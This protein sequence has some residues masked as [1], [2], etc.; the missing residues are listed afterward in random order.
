MDLC[1]ILIL[2]GWHDENNARDNAVRN[3]MNEKPTPTNQAMK[4]QKRQSL[5]AFVNSDWS[6][7]ICWET[8]EDYMHTIIHFYYY[9]CYT[10][11]YYFV[12]EHV[13]TLHS[14]RVNYSDAM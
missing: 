2:T 1:G 14:E 4:S 10:Y 13:I 11:Y 9:Y 3:H 5:N 8:Q 6:V 7:S 12:R